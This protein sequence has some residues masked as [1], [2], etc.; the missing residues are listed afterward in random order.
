MLLGSIAE[1]IWYIGR[2]GSGGGHGSLAPG[3][4][5]P[6]DPLPLKGRA[7]RPLPLCN[8]MQA[9]VRPRRRAGL[10]PALLAGSESV[11]LLIDR[12]L[13]L[14]IRVCNA[15]AF[16]C[17]DALLHPDAAISSRCRLG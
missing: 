2:G 12:L 5:P 8:G 9:M 4:R 10:P 15:L 11:L 17:H 16:L 1:C 14:G 6:R 13:Y 3:R 7:R